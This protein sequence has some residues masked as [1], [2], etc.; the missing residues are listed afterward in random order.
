MSDQ[1]AYVVRGATMYCNQ[2]THCRRI[3]LPQSHGSYVN[4]KSMMNV[5]DCGADNVPHFGICVSPTNISSEVIY[6]IAEDGSTISGKP[7]RPLFWG[8]WMNGKEGTLVDGKAALTTD[9][10]LICSCKGQISF[11]TD[12]QHDE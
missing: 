3:N 7:C 8:K 12:G 5:D 2:G 11:L 9:S 10:M 6:L 1:S 4:E